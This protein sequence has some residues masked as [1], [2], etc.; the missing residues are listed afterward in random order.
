MKVYALTSVI[1]KED[2]YL[3]SLGVTSKTEIDEFEFSEFHIKPDDVAT[4]MIDDAPTHG[5]LMILSF[6]NMEVSM[7]CKYDK[8][9]IDKIFA[10]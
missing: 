3:K 4:A 9:I 8:K 1:R 5:K 2:E 6:Y 7:S 10:E